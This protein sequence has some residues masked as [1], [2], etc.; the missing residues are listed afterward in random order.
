M[1]FAIVGNPD[2]GE[3]KVVLS[4]GETIRAEAG[5]MSRM[6]TDL[7]MT[8]R[9]MGGFLQGMI[10]RIVG[11]ESLFV[12]E[13]TAEDE[14]GFVAFAPAT[15]GCIQ[16]RTLNGDTL[17]LTA[18]AFMACTPGVN[19][20]PRFGG[21]KAFFSGEGAFFL[22]AS[23]SGELFFNGYGGV[24]EK[25]IDGEYIVDTGHAVAWEPGLQYEVTGMGGWK[26][27]LFSGEGLVLKFS[28]R[29]KIW[30][31]SRHMGALAKWLRGYC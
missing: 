2:Y 11:G 14:P 23:G 29:G 3:L 25:E 1:E 6:S 8:S 4:P 28:G 16:Q 15:P 24:I 10:R 5:S 22:E 26:Q 12:G 30:V 19:L 20:K 18:G 31:Q 17:I 7:A 21:L 13:Y 9:I 27:T